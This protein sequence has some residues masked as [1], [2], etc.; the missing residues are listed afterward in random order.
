M[1]FRSDETGEKHFILDKCP[2]F[3]CP[4]L[5][6]EEEK[7]WDCP[8]HGSRFDLDGNLLYGPS[9]QFNGKEQED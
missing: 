6:N 5:F 1:L 2:H 8:C 7:T 9:K 4:L 3:K